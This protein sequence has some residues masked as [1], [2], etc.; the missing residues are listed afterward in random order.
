[1]LPYEMCSSSFHLCKFDIA[2]M[3]RKLGL[4]W[5]TRDELFRINSRF[6]TS[7]SNNAK[8][9]CHCD[10]EVGDNRLS[11]HHDKCLVYRS[12]PINPDQGLAAVGGQSAVV[13]LDI[14]YKISTTARCHVGRV[15]PRRSHDLC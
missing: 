3:V 9:T 12:C 2:C 7:T 4:T 5:K 1:M 13:S 15:P 14:R 11:E 10:W 8:D 6:H